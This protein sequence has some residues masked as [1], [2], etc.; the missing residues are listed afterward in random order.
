M[1]NQNHNEKNDFT[2]TTEK[3]IESVTED[4]KGLNINNYN[5]L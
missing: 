5:L 2:F 3:P 4:K 1:T